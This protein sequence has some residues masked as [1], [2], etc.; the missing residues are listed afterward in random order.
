MFAASTRKVTSAPG[1][2]A[3][4]SEVTLLLSATSKAEAMATLKG[5][6]GKTAWFEEAWVAAIATDS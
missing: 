6:L 5:S 2:R 1:E 4:A 3:E